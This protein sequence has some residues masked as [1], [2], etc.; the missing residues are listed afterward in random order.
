MHLN[1]PSNFTSVIKFTSHNVS[2]ATNMITVALMR[3]TG[4]APALIPNYLGAMGII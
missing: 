1:N 3:K 4:Q 2:T